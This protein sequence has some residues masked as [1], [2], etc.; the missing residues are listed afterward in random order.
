[1]KILVVE[2]EKKAAAYLQKGLSE[3]G[4]VVD[5]CH[6]GEDGLHAAKMTDYD[7]IIL[8]IMLPRRDGL[9]VIS[10][11]R[12]AGKQTLALFLTAKDSVQDRVKGLDMGADAYL[13]K[14]F[15]FSELMAQVRVL[16]RRSPLRQSD[17]LRIADLEIDYKTCRATRAG[18]RLEL[19]PKEFLLLSLL[20]RRAGEVLP[21]TVIAE[22]VWDMNFDSGTNV[23]DVH[24]RGIRSKVDDPHEKKLIHT[25]RGMGYTLR[26]EP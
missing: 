20:A 5:V 17:L 22:Q 19:T 3:N 7:L 10:E 26:D 18:K 15:T 23:V 16:L 13:V 25:V 1:M 4:F 11:L 6:D 12:R 24:I 21:R 8:D 14:P 2:D 9:S